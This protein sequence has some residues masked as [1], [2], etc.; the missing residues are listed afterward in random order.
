MGDNHLA[1]LVYA[2]VVRDQIF[3]VVLPS[4]CLVK[5]V[6]TGENS[7]KVK[8]E[9]EKAIIVGEEILS[10]YQEESNNNTNEEQVT[11]EPVSESNSESNDT[12]SLNVIPFMQMVEDGVTGDFVIPSVPCFTFGTSLEF[13]EKGFS[14]QKEPVVVIPQFSNCSGSAC[15]ALAT[16]YKGPKV[17][18]SAFH[19][20][21][22]KT[23]PSKN[24]PNFPSLFYKPLII[25]IQKLSMFP[26][27]GWSR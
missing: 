24:Y 10:N 11:G 8:R 15:L 20:S 16:G 9:I 2:K 26:Q 5:D 13:R 21:L 27:S 17:S 19:R 25:S 18:I 6:N 23:V 12:N 22:E 1:G 14:P 7:D 3:Y 4:P